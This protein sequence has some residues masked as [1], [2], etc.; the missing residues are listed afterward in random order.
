MDDYV[1]ISSDFKNIE[2]IININTKI[3]I[4][5]DKLIN[6]IYSS[7]DFNNDNEYLEEKSLCKVKIYIK[8]QNYKKNIIECP[9]CYN[10]INNI[11][12]T[13]CN[14]DFCK[15]CYIKWNNTCNFNMVTTSCPLCREYIKKIDT[16]NYNKTI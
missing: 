15:S 1:K 3:N 11:F 2:E 16:N 13:S 7:F 14:H 5:N 10:Y 12:K 4:L 9:I 8:N 6:N